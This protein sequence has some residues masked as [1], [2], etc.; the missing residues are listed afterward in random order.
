MQEGK[1]KYDLK[2]ITKHYEY[3]IPIVGHIA[4][5]QEVA[6]AKED[7]KDELKTIRELNIK[8]Q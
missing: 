5:S 4:S 3:K 1:I 7:L 6:L 2:I 8:E